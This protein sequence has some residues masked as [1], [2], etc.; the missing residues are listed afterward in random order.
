MVQSAAQLEKPLGGIWLKPCNTIGGRYQF[1][2]AGK[3]VT[4][5][6]SIVSEALGTAREISFSNHLQE[7]QTRMCSEA[8]W[9]QEQE[10]GRGRPRLPGV[11]PCSLSSRRGEEPRRESAAAAGRAGAGGSTAARNTRGH[12]VTGDGDAVWGPWEGQLLLIRMNC[13]TTSKFVP[14][15]EPLWWGIAS[16][17]IPER[18]F[19]T[20][21]K[22]NPCPSAACS[23]EHPG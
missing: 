20:R 9:E 23:S 5:T 6:V 11:R 14:N 13:W 15:Y 21:E 12:S 4:G 1:S 19:P 18:H 17:L 16:I 8:C 10:Q 2:P 7:H 3:L 22:K